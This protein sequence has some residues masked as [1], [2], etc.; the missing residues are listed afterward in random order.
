MEL[1]YLCPGCVH[2]S[3]IYI[4]DMTKKEYDILPH[5]IRFK[6]YMKY[7][8]I[9]WLTYENRNPYHS[10]NGGTTSYLLCGINCLMKYFIHSYEHREWYKEDFLLSILHQK[11]RF[12][13][14]F[15]KTIGE[16]CP[17]FFENN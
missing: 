3:K 11:K 17:N 16:K 7:K 10:M 9:D 5:K 14:Q 4:T 6:M 1:E 2:T 13:D 8:P 12:P 15:Y